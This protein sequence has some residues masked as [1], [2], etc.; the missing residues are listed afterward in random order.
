M[1]AGLGETQPGQYELC[2][3]EAVRSPS[4]QTWVQRHGETLHQLSKRSLAVCLVAFLFSMA[5]LFVGILSLSETERSAQPVQADL[6]GLVGLPLLAG[7]A[8]CV[9]MI[10]SAC[11][12]GVWS[13]SQY[14]QLRRRLHSPSRGRRVRSHVRIGSSRYSGPTATTS[15]STDGVSA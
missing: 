3:A 7:A 9:G 8:F 10:L 6:V 2:P 1:L 12:Y 11:L 15:P 5:G 4:S 14:R 13:F